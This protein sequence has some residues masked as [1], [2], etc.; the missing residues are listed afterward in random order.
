MIPTNYQTLLN[1]LDSISPKTLING[2][3]NKVEKYT[4]KISQPPKNI[5]HYIRRYGPSVAFCAGC[6]AFPIGAGLYSTN[7]AYMGAHQMQPNVTEMYEATKGAFIMIAST[8]TLV[9]LAASG[10][11]KK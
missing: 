7:L 6:A 10:L 8:L 4:E 2:I 11:M 3:K 1:E 5:M 9:I